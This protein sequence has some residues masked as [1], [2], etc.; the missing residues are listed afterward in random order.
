MK[1]R[2]RNIFLV[3]GIVAVVIML[4]TFDVSYEQKADN[5]YLRQNP[6]VL[7]LPF[8]DTYRKEKSI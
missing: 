1:S 3:F 4:F 8:K 7:K 2:F 6:K 5:W